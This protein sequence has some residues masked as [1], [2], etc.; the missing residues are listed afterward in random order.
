MRAY[1]FDNLPG[2]QRSHHDS[3]RD[4]PREVLEGLG[5]NYWSIPV[6]GHE[7]K[8]ND[9]ARERD[10]KNRD[11]IVVSKEAMGDIYETKLKGF[12]EEHLH[13]DEEIRYILEGNGYFDVRGRSHL[14]SYSKGRLDLLL[15]YPET[16]TE[17][18]IRVAMGPGDL[19]IL[20]A[21]IYHRFTPD[22]NNRVK[23]MRLFKDE[24][25]WIPYNRSV[26]TDKSTSRQEYLRNISIAV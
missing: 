13:E 25:K 24:P 12:F 2:D 7:A 19:L 5:L 10:Y 8:I 21:G 4:V 1:Y 9:V 17:A 26:L 16:P 15:S 23:A 18:W 3:S 11:V 14:Y 6:D 20:P 22:E